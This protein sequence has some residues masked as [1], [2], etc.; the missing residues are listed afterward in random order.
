MFIR[1]EGSSN[2]EISFTEREIDRPESF[3]SSIVLL[4][5]KRLR[6]WVDVSYRFNAMFD[7]RFPD[8]VR[9][10]SSANLLA[11]A[12][13][14]TYHST[15]RRSFDEFPIPLSSFFRRRPLTRIA[16][17]R[18][19]SGYEKLK[20]TTIDPL[21]CPVASEFALPPI[22][23][24]KHAP[25]VLTV[26]LETPAG[27]CARAPV[28]FGTYLRWQ[29][30]KCSVNEV[31]C[32]AARPKG[33]RIKRSGYAST[34]GRVPRTIYRDIFARKRSRS[35]RRF[36]RFSALIRDQEFTRVEA[37]RVSRETDQG[38]INATASGTFKVLRF[39]A[40]FDRFFVK[41]HI[42]STARVQLHRSG[43]FVTL[44]TP[45]FVHG[46]IWNAFRIF[47]GEVN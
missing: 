4:S 15:I 9:D 30:P 37:S 35:H 17:T 33:G 18:R 10:R 38:E 16:G 42:C 12:F 31:K 34:E 20:F 45:V 24:G 32:A 8:N 43:Y 44:Y 25:P 2:E 14:R 28:N 11:K 40:H 21:R 19:T 47:S 6:N 5:E 27:T 26:E 39:V 22:Y 36:H 29:R 7:A 23:R 13:H 46:N 3:E 1:E 41:L